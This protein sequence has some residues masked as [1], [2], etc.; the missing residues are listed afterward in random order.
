MAKSEISG[1]YAEIAYRLRAARD[2]FGLTQKEFAEQADVPQKSYNQWE[3]GDFRIS[4][5]G[6]LKVRERFGLSLDFIYCGS[7]DALPHKIAKELSSIPLDT[8]SSRSND[9][10]ES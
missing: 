5:G 8:A 3:S 1:P 6:A 9:N 10:G 7:L 4:I 2:T